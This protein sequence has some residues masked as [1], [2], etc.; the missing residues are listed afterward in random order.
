[1]NYSVREQN[2]FKAI[3]LP[4]SIRNTLNR[5]KF[6]LEDIFD[7]TKLIKVLPINAIADLILAQSNFYHLVPDEG[8]IHSVTG[9]RPDETFPPFAI[10]N[11][12]NAVV[13]KKENA[14]DE[15]SSF[16]RI[17]NLYD[18]NIHYCNIQDKEAR[19]IYQKQIQPILDRIRYTTDEFIQHRR[20]IFQKSKSGTNSY[21][22]VLCDVTEAANDSFGKAVERKAFE[23]TII[24]ENFAIVTFDE[25][26]FPDRNNFHSLVCTLLEQKYRSS[27]YEEMVAEMADLFT[28][29]L[30][31]LNKK[32]I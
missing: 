15:V 5:H 6:Q 7:L 32:L 8:D 18:L 20:R 11:P 27:T 22:S 19:E 1:M 13:G 30:N 24:R 9:N 26:E 2:T 17:F 29:Y 3:L 14:C 10:T 4:L 12:E 21:G 23:L 28:Y 16:Y 25:K 31:C